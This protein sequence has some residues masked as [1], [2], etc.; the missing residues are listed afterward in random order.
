MAE[1]ENVKIPAPSREMTVEEL[2][3]E[4]VNRLIGV[5]EFKNLLFNKGIGHEQIDLVENQT[6]ALIDAREVLSSTISAYSER[7]GKES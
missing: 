4:Y 5:H 1:E 2:L 6:Q 7:F 3:N